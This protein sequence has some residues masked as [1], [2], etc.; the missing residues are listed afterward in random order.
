M[1]GNQWFLDLYTV[2][3]SVQD[4]T[5][6]TLTI[7]LLLQMLMPFISLIGNSVHSTCS[8]EMTV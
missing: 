4:D 3:H 2:R 1:Q 7:I 5:F 8:S 6:L